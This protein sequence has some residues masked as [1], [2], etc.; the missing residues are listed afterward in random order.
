PS[1][2][3]KLPPVL[4]VIHFDAAV[5]HGIGVA[6]RLLQQAVG[7]E[8]DGV[9]GPVTLSRVYAGNLP[10]IVSRYLLLRRDLYHNIV[11]K[12]PLQRRFLTGWLNRINKLRN[13]IPAVSR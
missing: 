12:N 4:K 3:D 10:E 11:N 13:F 7:V 6:N 9:I 2:A 8:V 5:K 1:A